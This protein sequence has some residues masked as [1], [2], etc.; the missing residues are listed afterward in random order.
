MSK[1]NSPVHRNPITGKWVWT[2]Q[3]PAKATQPK[4]KT[5]NN[6]VQKITGLLHELRS[7]TANL[8]LAHD[9]ATALHEAL[10]DDIA[11]ATMEFC[12]GL[13]LAKRGVV[14][15]QLDAAAAETAR[16]AGSLQ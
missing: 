7:P 3:R 8:D 6:S 15:I 4:E 5:M 2:I 16:D 14:Q 11:I 9:L 12:K 1:R 10:H 13:L